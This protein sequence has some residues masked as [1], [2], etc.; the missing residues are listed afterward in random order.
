M[1]EG[2]ARLPN[3]LNCCFDGVHGEA[4]ILSL[5]MEGIAVSSG[6]A[7]AAGSTEPSHVLAAMGVPAELA[8]SAV[9]MSLG[10]G[11]TDDDVTRVLEV[12]PAALQRLRRLAPGASAR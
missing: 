7:C 5:D 10:R 9:R 4:L 8:Q 11:T 6:S 3:T 1:G 2:A 12:L